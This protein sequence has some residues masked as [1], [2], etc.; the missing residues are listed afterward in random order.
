MFSKGVELCYEQYVSHT[1]RL[2]IFS[3]Y[4]GYY[5]YL[6]GCKVYSATGLNVSPEYEPEAYFGESSPIELNAWYSVRWMPDKVCT[7]YSY[8]HPGNAKAADADDSDTKSGQ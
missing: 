6:M 2:F 3:C 8:F 4:D 7:P 1:D 5:N